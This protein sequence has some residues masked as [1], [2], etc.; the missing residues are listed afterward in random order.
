MEIVKVLDFNNL[1]KFKKKL[2]PS[3]KEKIVETGLR[4]GEKMHE[5][6]FYN[7]K[8]RKTLNKKIFLLKKSQLRP[9]IFKVSQISKQFLKQ[10]I[11][12]I[13]KVY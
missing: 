1:I 11:I 3:Y 6:L 2:A 7:A 10:N 8:K 9:I 13:L 5:E 4:P 12:E